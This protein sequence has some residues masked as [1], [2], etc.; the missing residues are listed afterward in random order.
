M[1]AELLISADSHVSEAGDLWSLRL[2]AKFK[3]VAPVF[4]GRGFNDGR[5]AEGS[6]RFEN[7]SGGWDSKERL[8]EMSV[9]GVS[10]EVL[11]P[12]SGL[13]LFGQ[14]DPE[15]QE[16]CFRVYNDWLIEYCSVAP[17]RLLGIACISVY[18]IDHGIAEL[19]R[20]KQNGMKG[21]LVWQAPHP[22]LPFT[23]Q[24]YERFWASAQ[25]LEMPISMHI[26]TGHNYSK[27]GFGT[28]TGAES[29]R[30]SVNLKAF[31]AVTALF[32]MIFYGVLDRYPK[33]KLVIVENE[34]GWIPF[35]LQQWDYYYRRF[36]ETNPP[37][38]STKPSD[39]FYRQVF[40]TFFDD[41]A[42]GHNFSW[43]GLDNC[44]WS[45]DYPHPNS[46]WPH[47]RDTI[48]RDLGHLSDADRTKLVCSNVAGLY[49]LDIEALEPVGTN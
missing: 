28:R 16:A 20:C 10:A 44:M 4:P 29:Y 30:G 13:R 43:W 42:G 37:P 47:S 12:T 38:I 1:A 23:S 34:V 22:D 14:D 21:A 26:L 46:T 45:N 19:E 24:H 6:G 15:L 17:D 39:Y 18:D 3:D 2:P 40:A 41:A 48:A 27:A 33:L 36:H 25:E 5:V 31:D 32:D 8:K 7:K 35:F 11:Y 49:G 9:D